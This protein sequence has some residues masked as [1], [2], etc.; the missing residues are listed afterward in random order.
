MSDPVTRL[1]ND[2]PLWPWV[3]GVVALV[4]LYLLQPILM[5]FVIAAGLAYIGDPIVDWLQRQRLSRTWGVVLVFG[6][7]TLAGLIGALLILPLLQDQIVKLIQRLPQYYAWAYGKLR[8]L[9]APFLPPGEEM[10]LQQLSQMIAQQGLGAGGLAKM[11]F[12]ALAKPGMLF[13]GLVGSA[14]IVPVVTFYLLRDW[15]HL[16][17]H[18]RDLIPRKWLPTATEL[19]RESDDVLSAFMRGQLLVMLALSIYYSLALWFAGLELALLIGMVA[20]AISFVPYLG[21][22]VGI[23][24]ASI[25]IVVQTGEFIPLLWVLLIFGFGQVLEGFV[26]T[27]LLVG[28]RI[29][30]HPVAVMFAVL[31]GGALFGFIGVLLALPAAAVLAVMLRFMRRHYVSSEAYRGG[32]ESGNNN[33]PSPGNPPP[34]GAES[35]KPPERTEL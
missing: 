20:G 1:M 4:L 22:I 5:P 25:A 23:V 9:V 34:A 8:P 18:I 32:G 21:F 17:M 35:V 15:D 10:D 30:L 12:G 27:P 31:A 16:V 7:I 33:S 6:V 29:G 11:L 24:S 13:L 19:A 3:A 14:L 26:L 28:D 2:R